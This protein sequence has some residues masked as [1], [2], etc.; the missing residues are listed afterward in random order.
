MIYQ[1]KQQGDCDRPTQVRDWTLGRGHQRGGGGRGEL[2]GE[3]QDDH[4]YRQGEQVG[5]LEDQQPEHRGHLRL[6]EN[7]EA[8]EGF[9]GQPVARGTSGNDVLCKRKDE[10]CHFVVNH[11]LIY[12]CYAISGLAADLRGL[13]SPT[14]RQK[15]AQSKSQR[16]CCHQVVVNIIDPKMLITK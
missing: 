13:G 9:P 8:E 16:R 5:E 12:P 11:K 15:T 1:S 3:G 6:A 2:R 4:G 14:G 10:N 7:G